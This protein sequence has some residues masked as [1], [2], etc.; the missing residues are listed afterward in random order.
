M[1]SQEIVRRLSL[2][3]HAF[4]LKTYI[5]KCFQAQKADL[6]MLL[7]ALDE[8]QKD[9]QP[10]HFELIVVN[11]NQVIFYENEGK[12]LGVEIEAFMRV[13][14]YKKQQLG[15]TFKIPDNLKITYRNE[16]IYTW[17]ELKLIA[18]LFQGP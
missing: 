12:T 4:W 10:N 14:P 9:Q 5:E 6:M 18:C 16:P 13:M 8:N 3:E 7:A 11:I 1:D 17:Q 2:P 15:I